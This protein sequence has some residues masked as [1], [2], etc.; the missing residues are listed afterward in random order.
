MNWWN[1]LGLNRAMEQQAGK[2]LKLNRLIKII[3]IKN[4][5][6][7][8]KVI[9][10]QWCPPNIQPK[11]ELA[12]VVPVCHSP[13]FLAFGKNKVGPILGQNRRKQLDE[14][15]NGANDRGNGQQLNHLIELTLILKY[16]IT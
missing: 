1:L 11:L 12:T 14:K 2:D 13:T 15:A 4:D 6:Q 8:S 10:H 5:H 3:K 16:K 7:E 9:F